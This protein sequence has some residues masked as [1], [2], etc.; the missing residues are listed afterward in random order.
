MGHFDSDQS[1]KIAVAG[2]VHGCGAPIAQKSGDPE[3]RVER[4]LKL[5]DRSDV[6]R[7]V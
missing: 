2:L 6:R 7:I 5:C 3:L 1:A 4:L